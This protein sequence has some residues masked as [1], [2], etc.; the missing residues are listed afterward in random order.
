VCKKLIGMQ[1]P[2]VFRSYAFEPSDEELQLAKRSRKEKHSSRR[3]DQREILEINDSSEE[4]PPSHKNKVPI[5]AAESDSDLD[6][7]DVK[8]LIAATQAAKG[9]KKVRGESEDEET[10]EGEALAEVRQFVLHRI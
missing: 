5:S 3:G 4:T 6:F 8:S 7:P 10:E 1:G 2:L 9:K